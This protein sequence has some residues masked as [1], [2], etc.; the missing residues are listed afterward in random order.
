MDGHLTRAEFGRA[1]EL[2]QPALMQIYAA[3]KDALTR[4]Y[5]LEPSDDPEDQ[6]T[7]EPQE[8]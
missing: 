4:R 7:S 1:M 5:A 3:Q 8:G 2:A 6:A